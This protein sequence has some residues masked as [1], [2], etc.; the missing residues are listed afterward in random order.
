[1]LEVAASGENLLVSSSVAVLGL[2][3]CLGPDTFLKLFCIGS[4][5]FLFTVLYNYFLEV[6]VKTRSLCLDLHGVLCPR[7][8]M[9]VGLRG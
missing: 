4:I 5:V 7:F 8:C 2:V 9:S 3:G 6:K 1:M